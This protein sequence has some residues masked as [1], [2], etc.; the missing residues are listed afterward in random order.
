MAALLV[1]GGDDLGSGYLATAELYDPNTGTFAATGTMTEPRGSQLATLLA[2]GRVLMAGG[3]DET[4]F[5]SS[6]ELYWP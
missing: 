3:R 6:A 1:A 2:D 4:S 5:L